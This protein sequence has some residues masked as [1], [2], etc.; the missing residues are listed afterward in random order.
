MSK[1]CRCGAL[2]LSRLE[3]LEL[4]Y[5]P[6]ANPAEKALADAI[7]LNYGMEVVVYIEKWVGSGFNFASFNIDDRD[8][9]AKKEFEENPE[10]FMGYYKQAF[11]KIER[12]RENIAKTIQASK[13]RVTI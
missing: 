7:H 12:H 9:E 13:T 3:M 10:E 11:K 6:I 2:R 1:T 4:R 5:N 8:Q